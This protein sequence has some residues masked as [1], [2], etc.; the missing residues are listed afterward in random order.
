MQFNFHGKEFTARLESY[1]SIWELENKN[2]SAEYSQK[3]I[4]E[5][6]KE[7]QRWRV[8]FDHKD[9]IIIYGRTYKGFQITVNHNGKGYVLSNGITDAA[10][11]SL[12]KYA[13]EAAKV[14]PHIRPAL[15]LEQETK[16]RESV[17]RLAQRYRWWA[18]E[19]ER[20]VSYQQA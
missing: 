15:I 11:K 3:Y 20:A 5:K 4:M 6:L 12:Q 7:L 18:D 17:I 1:V 9:G 13:D 14:A 2:Y 8:T 19:L 16:L 10:R